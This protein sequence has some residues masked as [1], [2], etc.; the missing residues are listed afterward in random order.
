MQAITLKGLLGVLVIYSFLAITG[1]GTGVSSSSLSVSQSAVN[2]GSVAV[3]QQATQSLTLSNSG[4]IAIQ[5]Q[6]ASLTGTG[7]TVGGASM[8]MTLNAGQKVTLQ[9]GFKPSSTG[10]MSGQLAI[11]TNSSA[12][13]AQSDVTL[14]G[15]GITQTTPTPVSSPILTIN[16]TTLSFGTVTAGSTASKTI[17]LSSTGTA[18]VQVNSVTV[19]GSEF[20]VSGASFPLTLNP[21]QQATLQITFKP[22]VSGSD[23]GTIMVSSNSSTGATSQ[24]SLSGNAVAQSVATLSVS[25][26]S[27]SFGSVT[28]GS[29]STQAVTLSSTGTAAV[30]VSSAALS[31]SGFSVSGATFPLT[32]NPGQQ[33][34]LQV[35][36]KP[37]TSG[38]ATG[39]LTIGSNSSTGATQVV[40][41]SGSGVAQ[42]TP[43]LTVSTTSLNFGS[44]N[45]GSTGT[46]S[47]TLSSTGTAAVQVYSATLSG[48]AFSLTAPTFPVTLN[49][50]QQ[51]TLQVV[52]QPTSSGA[53]TGALAIT[54]NSSGS[55]T[56][57]VALS[58]TGV[59]TTTHSVNLTWSAPT[60]TPD[61]IAGYNVYRSTVS[62]SNYQLLNASLLTQLSFTDS[63]VQSATT[64]YYVVRSVD[65]TGLESTNSSQFSAAI[66]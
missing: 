11:A 10:N 1:C 34:A 38:T 24:V 46:Q 39:S 59:S 41:L 49:P 35:S 16:P 44:V 43:T 8:P 6:S 3:G 57:N 20:T 15:T 56:A 28:V 30:Q 7:F 5:L 52:F 40:A 42:T 37:A 21:G 33:V 47:V 63:N 26:G 45:V 55:T 12:G 31:G 50:G 14:S 51:L 66:P 29:T 2:F 13:P 9:V 62:G 58:G 36:F 53:V 18:A 25:P 61:P 32:L 4:P 22:S 54:S 23:T 64:Y 48:S 19:T 27:V 60:S 65:S 17:T